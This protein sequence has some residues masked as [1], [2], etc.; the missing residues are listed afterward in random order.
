ML[1]IPFVVFIA[2]SIVLGAF[3]WG[4]ANGTLGETPQERFDRQFELIV[5]Q[6]AD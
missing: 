3:V 2:F 5:R 6:L 4:W 1:L